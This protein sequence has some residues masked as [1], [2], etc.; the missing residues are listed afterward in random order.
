MT[1]YQ[2]SDA[3]IYGANFGLRYDF[4]I[5][6]GSAPSAPAASD[7]GEGIFT[8]VGKFFKN[9]WPFGDSA[10]PAKDAPAQ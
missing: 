5:G 6:G 3:R 2:A 7:S 10:E 8:T 1:Y 4:S 9:L